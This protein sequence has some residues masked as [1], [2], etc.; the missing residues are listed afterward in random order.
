M[1]KMSE[2]LK[3]QF[4]D[5]TKKE[6]LLNDDIRFLTD[7]L[8]LEKIRRDHFEFSIAA[9]E[10]AKNQYVP[11]LLFI[12]FVENAVKHSADAAK[13]SYIRLYFKLTDN[14]LHFTCQNSKPLQPRKK[15]EFSGL[16]LAN[17]RRRLDLL[18][19][20]HYSLNINE[21][22]STYTVQLAINI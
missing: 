22:E 10:H 4:N 11:P 5:S 6:V 1:H 16:G 12:P 14:R 3:Y 21:D 18:Y 7:F 13:L 8:N 20:S 17:S 9:D 15:N 19:D 2:M